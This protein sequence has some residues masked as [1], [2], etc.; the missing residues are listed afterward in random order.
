MGNV[1]ISGNTFNV[2][3]N[4]LCPR[5]AGPSVN[6]DL[7][8]PR[9]TAKQRWVKAYLATRIR[10][11]LVKHWVF[12]GKIIRRNSRLNII[13]DPVLRASWAAVGNW[14]NLHPVAKRL[15]KET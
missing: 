2:N 7:A 15:R 9:L 1:H 13:T 12:V 8:P 5:R 4:Q 10:R 14:L 6:T 11:R 3:V